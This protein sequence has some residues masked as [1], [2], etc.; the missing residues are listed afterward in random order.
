MAAVVIA[1]KKGIGR[2]FPNSRY[3]DPRG[4]R[5]SSLERKILRYRAIE[6]SLYLHVAQS[7]RE[8][9]I[10][11]F[12]KNGKVSSSSSAATHGEDGRLT[13]IL[14][15]LV[16]DAE[17]AGNITS[18]DAQTLRKRLSYDQKEGRKLKQ[19]FVC[20]VAEGVFTQAEAGELQGLLIYRN[21]IA[22]EIHDVMAD[23]SRSYYNLERLEFVGPAYKM[24]AFERLDKFYQSLYGRTKGRV[25]TINF[26]DLLFE[27]AE[28]VYKEE[29]CRLEGLILQQIAREKQRMQKVIE[30]CDLTDTEMQGELHPRHHLNKHTSRHECVQNAGRL[31]NRGVEVCYRL[32]DM[33]K[34]PIA[35]SYLM[36]I[37]LRSATKR[38]KRWKE[39]GGSKRQRLS[40]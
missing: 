7:V 14:T 13:E 30:E 10:Q 12:C 34:S 24:M 4:G 37:S 8:F 36:G 27:H 32:F 33:G 29:L 1:Y 26:R 17:L 5:A 2:T 18:E 3:N 40:W 23:V 9:M 38:Q 25:I 19:A 21:S 11:T 31:T 28:K 39:S 35:V 6:T 22:H 15:A 16:F 20:A